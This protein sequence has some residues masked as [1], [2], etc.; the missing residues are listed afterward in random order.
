VPKTSRAVVMRRTG[1]P[2]VLA[3][4]ERA[5]APLGPDDVRLRMLAAAVNH[6]DL[7]IRA[8]NWPLRREPAFPYVP[9]LEVVGDV[10]EVG[11]G[12]SGFAVGQRAWTA[13]QGLGG[14]RAERDGGYADHVTVAAS[15]LAPLPLDVDAVAFATLGLSGV[16]VIEA[17]RALGD[18]DGKRVLVAGASGSVGTIAVAILRAMGAHVVALERR[19]APPAPG[20]VDAVLDCVAGPLFA[21]LVSALV[22]GGRYCIVGAVAG[23]DVTFDVWSL[24]DGRSLTGYSSESLDGPTLSRA[25]RDLLDLKLGVLD[26][27]VLPLSDAARAH[28]RLETRTVRG[29]VVLVP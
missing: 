25:T 7:E 13:M 3:V 21:Q 23:G 29:R 28:E 10:V 14:V 15:V 11:A 26:V 24:L 19:S 18:V 17:V 27:T 12:V 22:A 9:G 2:G 4:E 16:T 20:S 6:S 5:L 1:G 8:G